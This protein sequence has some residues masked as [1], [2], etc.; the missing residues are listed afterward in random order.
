MNAF[1]LRLPQQLSEVVNERTR[2]NGMIIRCL[3]DIQHSLKVLTEKIETF[4]DFFDEETSWVE[5]NVS[6]RL[7][8]D[9]IS[10]QED[11][12]HE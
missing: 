7:F 4:I 5:E 11:V 9:N 12:D 3:H 10:T 2:A 1:H 8:A 6:S